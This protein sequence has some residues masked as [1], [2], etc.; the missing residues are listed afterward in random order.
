M[1]IR[2][3]LPSELTDGARVIYRGSWGRKPGRAGEIVGGPDFKNEELVWDVR[4]DNGDTRWGY[5]DQYFIEE[6]ANVV[7]FQIADEADTRPC[8]TEAA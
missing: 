8:D 2:A 5:L 1:S 4:L 3:A 6:N 7:A